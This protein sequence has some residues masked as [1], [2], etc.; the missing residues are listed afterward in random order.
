MR[1]SFILVL[2]VVQVA[3]GTPLTQTIGQKISRDGKCSGSSGATCLGSEFGNCCRYVYDVHDNGLANKRS[4]YGYC[5][6]STAYCG[7]GC[8]PLFGT[9]AG[10]SQP[11]SV[12]SSRS[13]SS[14]ATRTSS[15]TSPSSTLVVST[16]ARCGYLYSA[17]PGGMTCKGS[18]WGNCCSSQ[19]YWYVFSLASTMWR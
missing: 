13:L 16:N 15:L 7:K 3:L 8:N 19:S 11:A 10:S 6:K 2:A 4:Q 18:R 1:S 9:C 12:S 14:A 17:K 5:G